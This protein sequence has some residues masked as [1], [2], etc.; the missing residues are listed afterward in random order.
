MKR[1]CLLHFENADKFREFIFEQNICNKWKIQKGLM[2]TRGSAISEKRYCIELRRIF[3]EK[4]L[5]YKKV[6]VAEIV[7]WLD[8]FVH[9][10]RV[11]DYIESKH[12]SIVS[13]SFEI[14]IEYKIEMS[15][16]SRIDCIIKRNSKYCLIELRTVNGFERMKSAFD[17]KRLELMIYKDLM[18]NYIDPASKIVVLPFIGLYEYCGG[19]KIVGFYNNNIK[20]AEFC[21]DYI[22]RFVLDK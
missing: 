20:Q 5:F 7:S 13:N 21:C 12:G 22:S 6:S 2:N 3:D 16:M 10:N 14:L 17:K 9:L 8:T 18:L 1:D 11:F 19:E 15:K 4:K